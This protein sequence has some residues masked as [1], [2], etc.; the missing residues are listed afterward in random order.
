MILGYFDENDGVAQLEVGLGNLAGW[1]F[2]KTWPVL[3]LAHRV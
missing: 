3:D 2:N 1:N